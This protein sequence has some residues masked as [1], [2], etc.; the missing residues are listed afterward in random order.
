MLPLSES[1]QILICERITDTLPTN[2]SEILLLTVFGKQK[3][4]YTRA[5][6]VLEEYAAES[7]ELER[8]KRWAKIVGGWI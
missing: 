8:Y 1:S 3:A 6:I 5:K 2:T 7:Y 4:I